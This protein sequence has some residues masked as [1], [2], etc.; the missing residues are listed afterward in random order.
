V[1]II[2]D[3]PIVIESVRRAGFK[4]L[5]VATSYP[6]DALGDANWSV[7]SLDPSEVAQ[8]IPQLKLT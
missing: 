1:L 3:A 6:L 7:T 5:G 8:K 4:V 2:E